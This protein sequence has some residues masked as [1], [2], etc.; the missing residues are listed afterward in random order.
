MLEMVWRLWFQ[1]KCWEWFGDGSFTF[2]V[3]N[4][5]EAVVLLKC[6]EWFGVCGFILN[7]G[8]GFEMIVSLSVW[9][10]V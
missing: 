6:F 5:L 10:M 8:N 4:G 9:K 3:G 7:V 2:I 1:S